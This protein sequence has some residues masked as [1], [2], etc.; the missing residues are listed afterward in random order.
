MKRHISSIVACLAVLAF[1]FATF[2]APIE[3]RLKDGT[4]WR[5]EV[6][7]VVKVKFLEGGVPTE[8]QG[9][10][11][12]DAK[13]YLT[14]EGKELGKTTK[15]I[16]F[17]SDI[18]AMTTV[19][20]AGAEDSGDGSP[21]SSPK[22]GTSAP[23]SST[24][25]AKDE[26]KD[27]SDKSAKKQADKPGVFV[28]PMKGMV[29]KEVRTKEI[30]QIGKE[31][32]KYGDGQIIVLLLDTP[33]G[34][35]VEMEKMHAALADVKKRH[36][37]VAWIQKA[38][39]AGC[40][41][42]IHCDE[43]YFMTE[44]TAGSMTA[45]AG[46]QS[47]QGEELERWL[48]V[49]GDW[50]ELGGRNRWIA[51]SMIHAPILLSYDKDPVTGKVTFHN[52]LSGEFILSREDENLTFTSSVAVHCGFADGI[53]DT[54]EDLAKLLDLPEWHEINSYGRDIA[55]DW[56]EICERADKE[57]PKLARQY[58]YKGTGSGDPF[59]VIGTRIR[60]LEELIRWAE[61]A[62][63]PYRL[64]GLPPKGQ[65]ERDIA[66]LRKQISDMRR[67]QRNRGG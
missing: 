28:L 27:A 48:R 9:K 31:A 42:A 34:A 58:E 3:L 44:G 46:T 4:R 24:E 56:A 25:T 53:A 51:E 32:D 6:S 26:G 13:L 11:L 47:W 33:G 64:T 38:I 29:G 16:I 49:A 8:F 62:P 35:V 61:R 12:E 59:V 63:E 14:I 54:T 60:I 65:L 20:Q 41:T 7:D 66:G 23:A 67:N 52:D 39:S 10:I 21:A 40:A 15:K 57:L 19:E 22:P 45:F 2:A 30:V 36:R 18:T 50:A 37:L 5:G 17:K 43:I 1:T 55:K